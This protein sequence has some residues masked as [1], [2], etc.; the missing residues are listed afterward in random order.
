LG[1]PVFNQAV[2]AMIVEVETYA[3]WL[4]GEAYN[5]A[6]ESERRDG[7]WEVADGDEDR[8]VQTYG[9][10]Y[11]TIEREFPEFWPDEDNWYVYYA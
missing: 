1:E 3:A 10:L 5:L 4:R 9:D 2:Q 11:G 7:S 6:I 8:E